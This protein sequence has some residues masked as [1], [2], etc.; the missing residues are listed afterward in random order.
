MQRNQN[1]AKWLLLFLKA[2]ALTVLFL[3]PFTVGLTPPSA[4]NISPP[5]LDPH[6]YGPEVKQLLDT[7]YLGHRNNLPDPGEPAEVLQKYLEQNAHGYQDQ[8][9]TQGKKLDN[10]LTAWKNLVRRYP[11]SRHAQVALAKHYRAKAIASGDIAY[12]RQAA[13]AYI[14]AA[15]LGLA[16]GRIRYTRQLSQLL[17]ELGDRKGLDEV[18]GGIL[19]QPKEMDRDFYYLALVDYASGLAG[20]SDDRAWG[21]FE[22]AIDFYPENN[23][24]A[25]NV[26]TEALID[27]G[28]GEK[29]LNL[30]DKYVTPQQ[31][32]EAEVPAFLRREALKLAGRNTAAADAELALI[33]QRSRQG[34]SMGSAPMPSA[35]T[36]SEAMETDLASPDSDDFTSIMSLSTADSRVSTIW[37]VL[38]NDPNTPANPDPPNIKQ[39][40]IFIPNGAMNNRWP[41]MSATAT[42]KK[43]GAIK[44]PDG[45]AGLFRISTDNV[46]YYRYFNGSV[47]KKLTYQ[48]TEVDW[49]PLV[50]GCALDISAVVW[51]NGQAD[52]FRVDCDQCNVYVSHSTDGQSWGAWNW[53]GSCGN[54]IAVAVL[55]DSTAWATLLTPYGL[56]SYVPVTRYFNGSTW[57]GYWSYFPNPQ[58]TVSDVDLLAYQPT[59]CCA[60]TTLWAVETDNSSIY[61]R[62][63]DGS[64][65]SAWT[66]W[67]TG[68]KQVSSFST[69][70]GGA[71][72]LLLGTNSR[73]YTERFTGTAWAAIAPQGGSRTWVAMVGVNLDD[74]SAPREHTEYSDDCRT[75]NSTSCIPDPNGVDCWTTPAINLAEIIY[76][77]ARGETRGAQAMVGW[78]VRNRAFQ[79]LK[80]PSSCGTYPGA[81]GGGTVTTDCRN[82]V[83]FSDPNFPQ[84]STRYC[85][86]MHGGQV[87]WGTSGFQFSDEHVPFDTLRSGG[88]INMAFRI[89]NGWVLDMSNPGWR[90]SG[91]SGCPQTPQ[92]GT[93]TSTTGGPFCSYKGGVANVSQL[94]PGGGPMEFL[95]YDYCAS[96]NGAPLSS[97]KWYAGDICGNTDSDGNGDIIEVP[98]YSACPPPNTSRG[99]ED[100]FFWNRQP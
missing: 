60:K 70:D 76:N 66:L 43:L 20:F 2:G 8:L 45:R 49:W 15:E 82:T 99:S 100:N 26:Y 63:W 91:I 46:L 69:S 59:I 54:Q 98:R 6:A 48:G 97:C 17:G 64:N 74:D 92:C 24:E 18:F 33:H 9:T 52:V 87:Y 90:P 22:E 79:S 12:T 73:L 7:T 88:F 65:W 1:T 10:G 27:R 44:W 3:L 5:S 37:S 28:Q 32:L 83:P 47:W 21:Y 29:A 75:Q 55:P 56:N 42:G 89:L 80:T 58:L 96:T 25:I 11:H 39:D 81:Q 36:S 61:Y 19:A 40:A 93:P 67:T 62:N 34:V 85:C 86:A 51:P 71:Y 38:L 14:S 16:N 41:N 23:D 57:T 35:S 94:P 30:L 50:G 4:Q 68:F 78:T 53:W 31:R 84:E 72:L 77:E 95:S 13:D